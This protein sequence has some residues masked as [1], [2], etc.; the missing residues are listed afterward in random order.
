MEK[1]VLFGMEVLDTLAIGKMV[2]EKDLESIHG[3]TEIVMKEN[4]NTTA[5]K[6]EKVSSFM[7][8]A[9]DLKVIIRMMKD[10]VGEK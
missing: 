2:T 7:P 6:K 4:S 5:K 9:I 8:M 1:E 10:M 3:Q